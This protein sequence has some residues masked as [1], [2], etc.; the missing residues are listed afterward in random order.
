M[1]YSHI[2]SPKK[3][4]GFSSNTLLPNRE[5]SQS[6]TGKGQRRL[7]REGRGLSPGGRWLIVVKEFSAGFIVCSG[8]GFTV[9]DV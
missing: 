8:S 4:L 1:N 9:L 5:C 3:I 6:V 2:F 7:M